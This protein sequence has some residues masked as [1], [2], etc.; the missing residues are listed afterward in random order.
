MSNKKKENKVEENEN[1][2]ENNVSFLYNNSNNS[3]NNKN[4]K[5]KKNE[6]NKNSLK[7][8]LANQ[9][10]LINDETLSAIL[11]TSGMFKSLT[12]TWDST[13]FQ[14]KMGY[15]FNSFIIYDL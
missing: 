5:N 11:V 7:K 4:S 13:P 3:K 9:K 12:N 14:I 10:E 2:A 6:N 15:L 8:Y 1:I